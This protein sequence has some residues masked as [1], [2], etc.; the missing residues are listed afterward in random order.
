VKRRSSRA[1]MKSTQKPRC[2]CAACS[3]R[4]YDS[5][6]AQM[7]MEAE[8]LTGTLE[9]TF[10][11]FTD[12]KKPAGQ[13]FLGA[14]IVMAHGFLSAV[15]EAHRLG[16]NPG[17][18]VL[19]YDCPPHDESLRNRLITSDDEMAALGYRRKAVGA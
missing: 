18:A 15:S 11:Y 16:I 10:L 5:A 12:P 19:N 1:P 9:P 13:R 6:I 2:I 17:G 14:C 8:E 4:G 7:K 3:G